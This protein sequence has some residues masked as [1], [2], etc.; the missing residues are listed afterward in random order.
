MKYFEYTYLVLIA[1]CLVF[2]VVNYEDL[3]PN[4]RIYLL[5]FMG[6]FSF[7]F[8]YRRTVRIRSERKQSEAEEESEAQSETE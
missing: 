7:M 4:S 5:V 3:I 2:L 8:A 1:M 6:L